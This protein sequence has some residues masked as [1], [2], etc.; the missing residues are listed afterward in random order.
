MSHTDGRTR[1][2]L[3]DEKIRVLGFSN[4]SGSREEVIFTDDFTHPAAFWQT[5]GLDL[6]YDQTI[7]NNLPG[8]FP[9]NYTLVRN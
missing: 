4:D 7:D 8:S 5:P 3:M 9:V 6:L 1:G 2:L